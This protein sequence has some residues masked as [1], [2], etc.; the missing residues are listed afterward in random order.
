MTYSMD[1]VR[2][3]L[4][5]GE[6]YEMQG[7]IYW[8]CGP[9]YGGGEFNDP[10]SFFVNCN[11][12][13]WWA[14]AD[15]EEITPENIGVLE[16]ALKDCDAVEPRLGSIYG[17]SLFACRVRGMRP[18]GAAYPKDEKYWALFDAAGPERDIDKS[19]FGNPKSHPRDRKPQEVTT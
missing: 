2:R 13:F 16:Q 1:F 19:G 15:L 17:P 10:A 14:C 8:R 12:L 4:E 6:K 3:L 7:E 9:Q 11:D 5:L 18:Q